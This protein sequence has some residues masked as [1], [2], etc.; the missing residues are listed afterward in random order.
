M[1]VTKI[2][3]SLLLKFISK[4]FQINDVHVTSIVISHRNHTEYNIYNKFPTPQ[5]HLIVI[6]TRCLY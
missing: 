3:K 1:D 6:T 2:I 4:G 5:L